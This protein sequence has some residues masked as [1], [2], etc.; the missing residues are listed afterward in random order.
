M[1]FAL[2]TVKHSIKCLLVFKKIIF[3]GDCFYAAPCTQ[4]LLSQTVAAGWTDDDINVL[5]YQVSCSKH[6]TFTITRSANVANA[7]IKNVYQLPTLA[8]EIKNYSKNTLAR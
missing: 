4:S 1:T 3:L 5:L 2:R 7:A 8:C 6:S